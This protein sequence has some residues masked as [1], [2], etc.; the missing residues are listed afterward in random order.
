VN[1]VAGA[2]RLRL[3]I[4]EE[5]VDSEVAVG[6]KAAEL[7]EPEATDVELD[8]DLAADR[9]ST[10]LVKASVIDD[11]VDALVAV[12]V[13]ATE[14]VEALREVEAAEVAEDLVGPPSK[15][16][17]PPNRLETVSS[18]PDVTLPT[19]SGTLLSVSLTR[20]ARNASCVCTNP[21]LISRT[22]SKGA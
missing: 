18:M 13:N 6:R 14:D 22:S 19:V 16:P 20:P 1:G 7:V 21:A 3:V 15:P 10:E 9:D 5:A 17:K 2:T 11:A 12:V 8:I 4:A